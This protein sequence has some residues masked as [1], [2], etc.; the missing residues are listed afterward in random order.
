MSQTNHNAAGKTYLKQV[1][2]HLTC[3]KKLKKKF[4]EQ[5]QGDVETFLEETS[6]ATVEDLIQRFG[7]PS[8]LAHSYIETLD[9]D[10]LTKQIRKAKVIKRIVLFTCLGIFLLVLA[11]ASIIIVDNLFSDDIA[12]V[13]TTVVEDDQTV[14]TGVSELTVE[15]ALTSD[16]EP[17]TSI[18]ME[19]QSETTQVI[20][21][22]VEI[23]ES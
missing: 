9:A 5:M 7:K 6:N 19:Q 17:N 3:P 1:K 21:E 22:I 2:T 10:E 18:V 14:I 11:V 23:V 13:I 20:E 8:E 4:L 16:I 15:E 12:T